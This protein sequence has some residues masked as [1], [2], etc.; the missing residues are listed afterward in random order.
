MPTLFSI[1]SIKS[2]FKKYIRIVQLDDHMHFS[3][4]RNISISS[5]MNGGGLKIIMQKLAG[6]FQ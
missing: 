6:I 3:T 5:L 1:A 2:K 4:L